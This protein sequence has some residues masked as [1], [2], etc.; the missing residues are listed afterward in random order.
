MNE[1]VI[2]G[3]GY[4]GVEAARRIVRD[5]MPEEAQV[6]LVAADPWHAFHGWTAEVITG[7]VALPHTRVPLEELLPGVHIVHGRVVRV[8]VGAQ[9]VDVLTTDGCETLSYDQ[10]L[11]GVGSHDA[12][13]KVPGLAEHG[14]SLKHQGR[15]LGELDRHLTE[16]VV[17]AAAATTPDEK[18]RMLTV[19]VAGGGFTGTEAAAAIMQRLRTAAAAESALAGIEPHVHLVHSGERLVPSLRPRF[20]RVADYLQDQ[21]VGEG[22]DIRAGRRLAA[23][24]KAGATLDDGTLIP[25]ATVISTVGQTPVALPGTEELLRDP[26]GRLLTDRY[27]RVLPNVWAGGDTAAVPHPSGSGPCPANALWAIYHGKRAGRNIVRTLYGR[28]P[29]PF[30]F[31]GLGQA[32]SMGVGRGAAELYGVALTGWAAWLTRWIFFHAFMPSR[33][34]ALAT[35]REWVTR[36]A[37]EDARLGATVAPLRSIPS[38]A[39]VVAPS[40]EARTYADA[41]I[42]TAA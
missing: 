12:T 29:A 34:V 19:V 16:L 2:L 30:R 25:S 11:I 35:A 40:P 20:D 14:W 4:T 37:R 8:D 1:I 3:G 38:S 31:P 24:S 9:T 42:E 13:E 23:V 21:V 6:T 41:R 10:L 33:R 39:S 22:I 28:R 27:L 17:A 18:R 26:S 7:H 32:A 5:T 15:G 36:P